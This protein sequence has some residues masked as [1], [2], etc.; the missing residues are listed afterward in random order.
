MAVTTLS[1]VAFI[2]LLRSK[3]RAAQASFC[4]EGTLFTSGNN[5]TLLSCVLNLNETSSFF[6]VSADRESVF[7]GAANYLR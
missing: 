7:S 1:A 3:V 2:Y 4:S 6:Y 5:N